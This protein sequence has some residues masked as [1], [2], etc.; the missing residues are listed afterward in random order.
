MPLEFY[1]HKYADNLEIFWSIFIT[2]PKRFRRA[3]Q[4]LHQ[5]NLFFIPT[6]WVTF[7]GYHFPHLMAG[8]KLSFP[9]STFHLLGLRKINL[10]LSFSQF[11]RLWWIPIH[12]DC[13]QL[14]IFHHTLLHIPTIFR[15]LRHVTEDQKEFLLIFMYSALLTHFLYPNFIIYYSNTQSSIYHTF[16]M[17]G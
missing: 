3:Y 4:K 17:R 13:I 2:G 1:R 11:W 5:Q 6:R 12:F 10:S 7:S 14:S 15:Y 9:T 8:N 16:R